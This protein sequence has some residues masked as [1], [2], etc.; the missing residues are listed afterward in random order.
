MVKNRA[1]KAAARNLKAE[2]GITYPRALDLVRDSDGL[3][4][5][6]PV[7]AGS[8]N[9][10]R[11]RSL[12]LQAGVLGR[13]HFDRIAAMAQAAGALDVS[14]FDFEA[15]DDASSKLKLSISGQGSDAGQLLAL[16]RHLS[17]Q[18]AG[19]RRLVMVAGV[20][21]MRTTAAGD[22][23]LSEV[24]Q[25][26]QGG[27][28]SFVVLGG[29][30]PPRGYWSRCCAAFE[31]GA[32]VEQFVAVGLRSEDSASSSMRLNHPRVLLGIGHAPYEDRPIEADFG[33]L[34]S[35]LV[36]G[37][38]IQR[39][40]AAQ[41]IAEATGASSWSGSVTGLLAEVKDRVG[42]AAE[43]DSSSGPLVAVIDL[44]SLTAADR[45]VVPRLR[46]NARQADLQLVLTAQDVGSA[47]LEWP[48]ATTVTIDGNEVETF[49]LSGARIRMRSFWRS[50]PRRATPEGMAVNAA[51]TAALYTGFGRTRPVAAPVE[52]I[53]LEAGDVLRFHG[54]RTVFTVRAVSENFAVATGKA[55]GE[56]VYTIIDWAKGQRGPQ[57]T[58]GF[59]V[60]S[61]EE[62][63][64]LIRALEKSKSLQ[65]AAEADPLSGTADFP[66]PF[67]EVE[68][69]VRR[70]VYVDVRSVHR[71]KRKIWPAPAS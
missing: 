42:H 51:A 17:N 39:T 50:R 41:A 13:A 8:W 15:R 46:H 65:D 5:A 22:R 55:R 25:M 45:A 70:A 7:A 37:E 30:E 32:P 60:T 12:W 40:A 49:S 68:L 57:N 66:W 64:T 34:Q 28:C 21:R 27:D 29:L 71:C 23:V 9:P 10:L 24:V 67:L 61:D 6:F 54:G 16:L 43:A 31:A 63:D 20:P 44:D 38:Q 62:C 69:S 3:P 59:S 14:V 19:R 58:W 4:V 1:A 52:K 36:T 53:E 11:H 33:V 26:A 48:A 47:R 56:I 2:S 18:K 35:I